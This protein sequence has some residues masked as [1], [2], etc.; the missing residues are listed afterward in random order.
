MPNYLTIYR[1]VGRLKLDCL[2]VAM[3]I[4][5]FLGLIAST[6]LIRHILQLYI[7]LEMANWYVSRKKLL[8]GF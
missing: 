5:I 3:S 7:N 8:Y 2:F 4:I 1:P 6:K